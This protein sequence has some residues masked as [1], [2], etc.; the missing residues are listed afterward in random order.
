MPATWVAERGDFFSLVA[1]SQLLKPRV[2]GPL[3]AS[4]FVRM[5]VIASAHA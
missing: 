4:V 1:E 5:A 3:P 2:P